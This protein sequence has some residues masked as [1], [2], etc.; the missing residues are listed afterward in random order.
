M[1][2]LALVLLLT[3]ASYTR[4]LE[5]RVEIGDQTYVLGDPLATTTEEEAGFISVTGSP[6]FLED[7]SEVSAPRD[8]GRHPWS[9][10]MYRA[11]AEGM[12]DFTIKS[13]EPQCARDGRLYRQNLNNLTL[14]ASRSKYGISRIPY[15][16]TVGTVHRTSTVPYLLKAGT[17]TS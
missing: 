8:P 15:Q 2:L 7:D 14:W 3:H 17:H 16:L 4:G 10:W 5:A 1:E 6:E 11:L 12:M 13:Q 9:G